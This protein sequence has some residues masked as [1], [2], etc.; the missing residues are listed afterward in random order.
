MPNLPFRLHARM[1]NPIKMKTLEEA[2]EHELE[3]IH[4]NEEEFR[5]KFFCNICDKLYDKAFE[6]IHVQM[7]NGEEKFNCATCNKLFP[8]ETS[9]TM[10]MNAHQETRVVCDLNRVCS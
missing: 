1:H 6:E 7:H 5:E 3:A 4:M 8:N 10:H 9:L 2:A